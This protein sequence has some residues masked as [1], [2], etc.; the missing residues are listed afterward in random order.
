V[1][2]DQWKLK[3]GGIHYLVCVFTKVVRGISA[4][5]HQS[6]TNNVRFEPYLI[7]FST[8][9]ALF[10]HNLPEDRLMYLEKGSSTRVHLG[11]DVI[12]VCLS[13]AEDTLI[14]VRKLRRTKKISFESYYGLSW[15]SIIRF[16][17]GTVSF[18][19]ERGNIDLDIAVE[20]DK[21]F[22]IT[23]GV[24]H[25]RII[26]WVATAKGEIRKCRLV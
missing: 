25:G 6:V 14:Y 15:R 11:G 24:E 13:Q 5:W 4:Y 2:L 26:A 9:E 18:D 1:Q 17:A 7:P 22:S 16:S 12:R 19:E 20:E 21:E 10:A 8:R 3:P 23:T